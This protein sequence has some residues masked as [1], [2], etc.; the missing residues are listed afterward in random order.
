M[1]AHVLWKIRE[2][3]AHILSLLEWHHEGEIGNAECHEFGAWSGDNV[4]EKDFDNE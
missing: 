2:V 1:V 3:H 4:V